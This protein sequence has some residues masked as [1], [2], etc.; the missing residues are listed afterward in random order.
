MLYLGNNFNH[1]NLKTM[2]K[3][4]GQG[5]AGGWPSTTGNKSGGGRSNAPSRSGGGS[6]RS[7][8]ESKGGSKK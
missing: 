4:K 8:S 2:S 1:K 7:S 3:G 6:N 5:N